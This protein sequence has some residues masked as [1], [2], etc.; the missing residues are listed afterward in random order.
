M[1]IVL[2]AAILLAIAPAVP[3]ETSGRNSL[4]CSLAVL[5]SC[6][7]VDG[8]T[9]VS[10]ADANVPRF[11]YVDFK[12]RQ[13]HGVRPDGSEARSDVKTVVSGLEHL[14]LQGYENGRA[15]SATIGDDGSLSMAA[16]GA[17]LAM[18]G[19]GACEPN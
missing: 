16:S 12:R 13:I 10:H 11:F 18:T 14:T 7:E 15:W 1:R 19:F 2:T 17:D 3:A 6:D 5:Q 9:R 4:V 8:C